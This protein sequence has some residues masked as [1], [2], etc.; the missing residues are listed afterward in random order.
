MPLCFR[1]CPINPP[2][3]TEEQLRTYVT[4][5][6]LARINDLEFHRFQLNSQLG[7][8][9]QEFQEKEQ[10]L[11]AEF[12]AKE[13]KWRYEHEVDRRL[14]MAELKL[15]LLNQNGSGPVPVPPNREPDSEEAAPAELEVMMDELMTTKNKLKDAL[16]EIDELKAVA[17]INE[18]NFR[19]QLGIKDARINKLETEVETLK[20]RLKTSEQKRNVKLAELRMTKEGEHELLRPV[21]KKGTNLVSDDETEDVKVLASKFTKKGP[22]TEKAGEATETQ[23]QLVPSSKLPPAQT[24]PESSDDEVE[25]E[26]LGEVNARNALVPVQTG[27]PPKPKTKQGCKQVVLSSQGPQVQHQDATIPLQK[28]KCAKCPRRLYMFSQWRYHMEKA[29]QTTRLHGS[30]GCSACGKIFDTKR[31]YFEHRK[32]FHAGLKRKP[33]PTPRRSRTRSED[34]EYRP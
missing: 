13:Q 3:Q 8:L 18:T 23:M 4:Q 26:F 2:M 31:Q 21:K 24:L 34:P 7:S 33:L 11:K 15:L 1:L 20:I 25:V 28:F 19:T 5:L 14:V 29:H 10:K 17:G 12:Q 6:Q 22:K 30:V 32:Q 9:H 16:K 27:G